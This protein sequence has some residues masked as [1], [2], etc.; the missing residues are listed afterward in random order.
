MGHFTTSIATQLAFEGLSILDIGCGKGRNAI[1]LASRGHLVTGFDFIAKATETAQI[2]AYQAGVY[3]KCKF[4]VASMTEPWPFADTEFDVCLDCYASIEIPGPAEQRRFRSELRRVLRPGG[5]LCVAVVSA[6]DAH[7]RGLIKQSPGPLANSAVWPENNKFQ[8][9]Y[10]AN[11]LQK[12]F[13]GYDCVNCVT[14]QKRITRFDDEVVSEDIY[15]IFKKNEDMITTDCK[16]AGF[17]AGSY[18]WH[19]PPEIEVR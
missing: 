6:A 4:Y 13:A 1:Y 5:L 2:N 3:K 17:R 19:G 11:E 18:H 16:E 10:T 7:E 8:K 9:N 15:A 12:E 14:I